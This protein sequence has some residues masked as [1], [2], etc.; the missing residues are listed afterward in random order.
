LG[1][2]E[3]CG[4]AIEKKDCGA[5]RLADR[6]I[7]KGDLPRGRDEGSSSC[8]IRHVAS[9]TSEARKEAAG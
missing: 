5:G 1:D 8:R 3:W 6:N 9:A 7:A 2:L 4:T